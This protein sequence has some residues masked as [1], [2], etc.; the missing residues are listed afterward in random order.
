MMDHHSARML[1]RIVLALS[2]VIGTAGCRS[3]AT[4]YQVRWAKPGDKSS[5]RNSPL[6][7]EPKV[8]IQQAGADAEDAAKL[9]LEPESPPEKSSGWRNLLGRFDQHQRVRLPRTDLADDEGTVASGSPSSD[10]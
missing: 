6:K 2:V 3:G 10:F 9:G 1:G 4:S 5:N 8:E 7:S